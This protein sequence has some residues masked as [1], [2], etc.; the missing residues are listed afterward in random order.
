MYR[1][2]R[3]ERKIDREWRLLRILSLSTRRVIIVVV[4]TDRVLT[5]TPD[6][7]SDQ[8]D[9]MAER[10]YLALLC[11]RHRVLT[12]CKIHASILPCLIQPTL[13][14]GIVTTDREEAVKSLSSASPCS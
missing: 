7:S 9:S 11:F 5:D 12:G 13:V 1:F 6:L 8:P 3:A 2:L 4:V 14:I 10:R